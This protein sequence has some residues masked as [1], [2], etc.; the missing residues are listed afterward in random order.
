MNEPAKKWVAALRSGEFEQGNGAL[1]RGDKFC[2]LGVACEL[3]AKYKIIKPAKKAPGSDDL[4]MYGYRT[5][6][7]PDEVTNWLNLRTHDGNIEGHISL[8]GENDVKDKTFKE[9]A[10]LI[11]SE[12]AGLFG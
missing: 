8:V 12:P 4:F 1:R 2:C 9:I 3:A 5:C 10:D 11:A 6:T 7:L